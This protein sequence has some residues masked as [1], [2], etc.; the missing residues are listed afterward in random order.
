LK[1]AIYQHL[2]NRHDFQHGIDSTLIEQAARLFADWLYLEELLS[3]DEGKNAW[4]WADALVKVHNMLIETFDALA[5]TPKLR[6]RIVQ[7][8]VKDDDITI[9]L[10]KL[11]G[12][13]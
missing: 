8:I 5:V 1:A 2:N 10:K 11:T 6:S 12:I 4:K 13:K 7:D 3:S 9:Q